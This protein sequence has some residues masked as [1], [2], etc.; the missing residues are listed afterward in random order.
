MKW[1]PAI[2]TDNLYKFC[3]ISGMWMFFG[4]VVLYTWIVAITIQ[5]EK[6]GSASTS[7]YSS[8]ITVS[9]IERRLDSIEKGLEKENKLDWTSTEWDI[10]QEKN[11]LEHALKNHRKSMK[12]NEYAINSDTGEQ[13]NLIKRP[14]VYIPGLLYL[15]LMSFLLVIGFFRWKTKI[16]DI[17]LEIRKVELETKKR[18]LVKLDLEIR[19]LNSKRRHWSR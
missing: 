19:N 11:F 7:Y 16:Q 12:L 17:D 13:L 4:L 3:A 14:A 18:A 8:L 15:A 1:M 5:I 9:D 10:D 6:E 2:P